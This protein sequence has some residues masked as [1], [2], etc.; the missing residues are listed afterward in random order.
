MADAMSPRLTDPGP[1]VTKGAGDPEVQAVKQLIRALEK[2]SKSNRTYGTTNAIAQ[3]FFR[4][5]F[6]ELSKFLAAHQLLALQVHRSTLYFH[7]EIVY[8][9][10]E[11]RENL[12][13]RLYGDGI[14]EL[15]FHD[16]LVE[17]EL[18]HFLRA[19][20]RDLDPEDSEEDGDVVTRLWEKNV[21]TI[22][23][24]TAEAIM[25]SSGAAKVLEAQ[26]SGTLN[27][28][29]SQLGEVIKAEQAR[30]HARGGSESGGGDAVGG[31]VGTGTGR[32]PAGVIGY[33]VSAEEMSALAQEVEAESARDS[34]LHL[35]DVLAAILESD[36][37]EALLQK[38]MGLLDG[39]LTD[40]AGHGHWKA[41]NRLIEVLERSCA[42]RPEQSEELLLQFTTLIEEAVSPDR[43]H[44]I[45]IHM[46]RAPDA[47]TDGLLDFL[48]RTPKP[49]LPSLF[50]LLGK[51]EWDD[52]RGVVCD[53][54][55]I[56]AKDQPELVIRGLNDR[57]HQYVQD[58]LRV[59]GRL[60][61]A[62]FGEPLAKLAAHVNIAIRREA[63]QVLMD[64]PKKAAGSKL[65]PFVRDPDDGIRHLV[66]NLLV[67]GQYTTRFSDWAPIV[68]EKR[69]L[70][71]SALEQRAVFQAMHE[72]AGE[73]CV[74]YWENLVHT[75]FWLRRKK[76]EDLAVLA[77]EALAKLASAAARAVLQAGRLRWNRA[78]RKACVGA[79]VDLTR[80]QKARGTKTDG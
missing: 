43:L 8:D 34:T 80:T 72:T 59:A 6:Q 10:P 77:V 21:L 39:V 26:N 38:L 58:M 33:E 67:K 48:L 14:R 15:S 52:H 16:G 75:T 63:L 27:T 61:D 60:K 25:Q 13:F 32:G 7:D 41:I 18:R 70:E 28:P 30:P 22:S 64:L 4:E 36:A 1:P 11:Q 50:T 3:K 53:A 31:E 20:W 69:F 71:R 40:L 37:S 55:A 47:S 73:E 68:T 46:N 65:V 78:I 74:P 79:L 66:V 44:Q 24:L 23:F 76:R 45:E 17:K 12:A 9:M 2:A 54:L 5:F 29:E 19:L 62:L 42:S 57:R 51:M 35:L 49:A 56:L